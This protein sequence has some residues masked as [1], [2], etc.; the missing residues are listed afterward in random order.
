MMTNPEPIPAKLITTCTSVN[1]DVVM[2]RIMG[3][4]SW[5]RDIRCTRNYLG[6]SNQIHKRVI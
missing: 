5:S 6:E 3:S 1:V 4:S 2:P